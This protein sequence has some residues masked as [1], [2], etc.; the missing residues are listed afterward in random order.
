[1][2]VQARASA[3]QRAVAGTKFV[4]S[5][6]PPRKYEALQWQIDRILAHPLAKPILGFL[7]LIN[8]AAG[9]IWT[10]ARQKSLEDLGS[11]LHSGAAYREGLNPY[12]YYAWVDPQPI[13][14]EALNLN[15]PVS[16]YLF[17]KLSYL[18]QTL[19]QYAFLTMSVALLAASV[20]LLLREY[21]QRRLLLTLVAV[22]SLAGVWHT[23][24][25]LQLY[26][27][28]VLAIVASWLLLR[29]GHLLLAG[30]AIG[31]VIAIKPNF[32]LLPLFLLAA[33]HVRIPVAAGLTAAAVSVVPLLLDGPV[34]YK[35]WLELTLSFSGLEW[36]SNTS[37]ISV[38]SR[39]GSPETGMLLA[40]SLVGWLLWWL[41]QTQPDS[42]YALELGLLAVLLAS[43]ASWAGYTLFL[44]PCLLSRAWSREIWVCVLLLAVP[45]WAVRYATTLGPVSNALLGTTYAWAVLL[46]LAILVR[47]RIGFSAGARRQLAV[48]A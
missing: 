23:L 13:S 5:I 34:I 21:P 33:N 27:P 11:F 24:G 43:P 8:I 39:F 20:A 22:T 7:L 6:L 47:E 30:I 2:A 25:Y 26:A 17:D 19:L 14:R 41:R 16:V 38:G 31:L 28:L 46:L 15:P 36:S 10:L 32:A 45:F 1:M 3:R 35:Q 37:L 42:L 18:D 9:I 44:L 48:A 29:H 12:R 4:Y 40:V